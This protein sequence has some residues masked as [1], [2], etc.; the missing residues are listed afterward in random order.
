MGVIVPHQLFLTVIVTAQKY[1]PETNFS[2]QT[3]SFFFLAAVQLFKFSL[4]TACPQEEVHVQ[5]APSPP[6]AC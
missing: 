4:P 2:S 1:V 6:S 3:L 5:P